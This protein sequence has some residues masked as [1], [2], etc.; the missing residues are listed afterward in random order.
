MALADLLTRME[1]RAADTSDTA[2]NGCAVSA[3]PLQ[4]KACTPDTSDTAQNINAE[5]WGLFN[6]WLIDLIADPDPDDRRTCRQCGKLSASGGICTSAYPGGLVS[7]RRGYHPQTDTP[8]RCKGFVPL[9][10][11]ADQRTGS[12]RWPGLNYTKA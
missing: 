4:D 6:A 5:D 1:S 12:Q 8:Q 11:E 10:D 7:A 9:S 2:C 3:K